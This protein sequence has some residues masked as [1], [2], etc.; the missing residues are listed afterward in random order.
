MSVFPFGAPVRSVEQAD[1]SPKPVFVLGVYSSAVHARWIGPDGRV[2]VQALAVASEPDIFWRGEGAQ[3]I[4][5]GLSIPPAAG[6]LVPARPDLNGSAGRSLDEQYFPRMGVTRADAWLCDLLPESRLN[7]NQRAALERHYLPNR[8]A[9]GLP[10]FT[11]PRIEDARRQL[12]NDARRDAI[13]QQVLASG[14]HTF[15]TLG[16]EPLRWFGMA[17]G[18]RTS[19]RSY[20]ATTEAYGR[21]HEIKIAGHCCE[22]LPLVHPRQAARLGRSNQEWEKLHREW[23]SA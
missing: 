17:F 23:Y 6:K 21:R 16:D 15:V 11:I 2:L 22:L 1:R 7:P 3:E 18:A 19:V 14:C 10:E 13:A 12:V 5:D 8:L 9:W 4:I 20:G